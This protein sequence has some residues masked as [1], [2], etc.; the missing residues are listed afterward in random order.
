MPCGL[1]H[2]RY[3]TDERIF[4]TIWVRS[5]IAVLSLSVLLLPFFVNDYI[6]Y[7]CNTIFIFIVGAI[8]LNILTGFTGQI[9]IGHGAF[10]AIGAYSSAILTTK[11]SLPFWLSLPAGGLCALLIGII[12]GLP[13]LRVKG[14]YLAIATLAAQFITDYA[15]VHW[16]SMTNGITGIYVPSPKFLGF[17][18]D[19]D[20]KYYYLLLFFA[21]AAAVSG[22]NLFRTKVGRALIAVR[23]RDI[24]ANLI[25]ISLF[26]YKLLAFSVSSFYAGVAGSLWGFYTNIITPEHFTIVLSIDYLAMIIVGGLGSILGTIFG[27]IFMTLLPEVLTTVSILLKSTFGQITTLLSA[28]KGLVFA[29][30]VILFLVFEPD[31][32]AEIWRRVKAYWKLWPFSY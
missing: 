16:E 10:V 23:D 11:L 1:F 26:R 12:F 4:Q 17:N 27:V 5:W 13:S 15:I 21:V 32:L 22:R 18:F 9:S 25:G 24:A 20:S 30:T 19:S 2:T 8:G 3:R 28:I 14:L 31:G 29:L 7:V 6:L